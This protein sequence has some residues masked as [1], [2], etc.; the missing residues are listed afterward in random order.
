MSAVFGTNVFKGFPPQKWSLI[1]PGRD[2]RTS[3]LR[4]KAT[5]ASGAIDTNGYSIAIR[6][7]SQAFFCHLLAKISALW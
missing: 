4:T 7:A 2:G 6:K 1:F 3:R 5:G